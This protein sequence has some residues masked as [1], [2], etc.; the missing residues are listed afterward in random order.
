MDNRIIKY[1]AGELS[2][3]E[4]IEKGD[5]VLSATAIA[6]EATPARETGNNR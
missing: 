3:E 5:D 4:R 6:D 1:Y 2:K